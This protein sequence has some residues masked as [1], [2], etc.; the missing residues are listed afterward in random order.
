[1]LIVLGVGVVGALVFVLI[2]PSAKKA[3]PWSAFKPKGSALAMERQIATQV[4]A[5]YKDSTESRLVSVFPGPLQATQF[6]QGNSGTQSVQV[7]ISLVA[8][9]ADASKGKHE[10]GDYSFFDPHSTVGYAM[11]GIGDSRQNCGV[12]NTTGGSPEG[13]LR[14]EALEIALYTLKYVPN[15]DA[16]IAYLPPPGDPGVAAKAILISRKDVKANLDLP[17]RRTLKP[18]QV[19]LGGGLPDGGHV[20]ELTSS[21]IY[22]SNYQTLPS[23]GSS[24][25]V[26]TPAGTAG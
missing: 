25:L 22:T 8:V 23:D 19:V 2:N 4:S 18:Q 24:A 26:L 1:L 15:T 3:P 11:C 12:A 5:E 9:L 13:L 20:G 17:L 6:V 16:V 10:E 14:R 21:R 7:P